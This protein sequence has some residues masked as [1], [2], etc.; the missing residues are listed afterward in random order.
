[1]LDRGG[2][3]F[4]IRHEKFV[5]DAGTMAFYSIAVRSGGFLPFCHVLPFA[6]DNVVH[7]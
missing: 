7:C 4:D 1:M 2:G 6:I 5:K 3:Y